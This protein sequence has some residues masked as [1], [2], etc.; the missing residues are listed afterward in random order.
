MVSKK[1]QNLIVHK[2][3]Q[4]THILMVFTLLGSGCSPSRPEVSYEANPLTDRTQQNDSKPTELSKPTEA[5]SS[6]LT[7]QLMQLGFV[8]LGNTCFANS[9]HKLLFQ[10]PHFLEFLA[11]RSPASKSRK[12]HDERDQ[13]KSSF[14]KLFQEMNRVAT[15]EKNEN[16]SHLPSSKFFITELSTVFNHF[17]RYLRASNFDGD[18]HFS[19]ADLKNPHT[20]RYLRKHQL[21]ADE[22]LTRTLDI[23]DYD[24]YF[25]TFQ[26]QSSLIFKDGFTRPT[27]VSAPVGSLSLPIGEKSVISIQ[28]AINKYFGENEVE[29]VIRGPGIPKE[30]ALTK[31]SL[32]ADLS[33][34]P[35]Q[36]MLKLKRFEMIYRSGEIRKIRK[37]IDLDSEITLEVTEASSPSDPKSLPVTLKYKI[38]GVIVHHGETPSSGHYITYLKEGSTGTWYLHDDTRVTA[39][40]D[41]GLKQAVEDMESNGYIFLYTAAESTEN[42]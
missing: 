14:H 42:L 34:L 39:I 8:N 35:K 7:L 5:L 12:F 30:D 38:A 1:C 6:P 9:V 25:P 29:D 10:H 11:T 27:E 3:I 4:M 18:H 24:E 37:N 17:D 41:A 2:L 36:I 16:Q 23:L 19:M 26:E 21:D 32:T 31:L 22:Y 15:F 33:N 28:T 20:K 13:L 40:G